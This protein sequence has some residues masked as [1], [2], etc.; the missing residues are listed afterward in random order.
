MRASAS[1][2]VLTRGHRYLARRMGPYSLVLTRAEWTKEQGKLVSGQSAGKTRKLTNL[3]HKDFVK[4]WLS[5]GK[6]VPSEVLKDYPDLV[7]PHVKESVMVQKEP[8]KLTAFREIQSK[9]S[10][11]SQ[12][13]DNA[14]KHSLTLKTD[15]KRTTLWL[16]N[17]GNA[18]IQGVDTPRVRTV[19]ITTEHE[20]TRPP[21]MHTPKMRAHKPTGK[22]VSWL[23]HGIVQSGRRRHVK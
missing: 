11:Q 9:R 3:L 17:Q 13:M 6:P 4:I 5:E 21:K 12:A 16:R 15:D 18:D 14:Q 10:P 23:G 8:S 19:R 1:K 22:E 7:K 20:K 2:R